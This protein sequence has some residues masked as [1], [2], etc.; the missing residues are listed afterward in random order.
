MA[1]II[2]AA[3]RDGYGKALVELGVR[4]A[5]TIIYFIVTA[6]ILTVTKNTSAGTA[7]INLHPNA[8][9]RRGQTV[10]GNI[11][12]VP[13]AE[14]HLFC[15]TTMSIIQTTAA[16]TRSVIILS[17][18]GNPPP[19]PLPPCHRFSGSIILSVCGIPFRLLSRLCLCFISVKIPSEISA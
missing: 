16:A 3:T 1:D 8:R 15:T 12:P 7:I 4:N 5:T 10:G 19:L 14:K 18:N 6:K 17:L 2:K 11:R 9:G 13:Y